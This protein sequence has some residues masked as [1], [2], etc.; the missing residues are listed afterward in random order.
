MEA[1]ARNAGEGK[2]AIVAGNRLLVRGRAL[3]GELHLGSS[4][5]LTGLIN[6]RSHDAS[7]Q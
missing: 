2:L 1:P 6:D 7:W 5:G 4:D 3:A